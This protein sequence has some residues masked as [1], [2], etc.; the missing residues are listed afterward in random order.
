MEAAADEL[1]AVVRDTAVSWEDYRTV[2]AA[3]GDE[4]PRGLVLHV[5]GRTIEGVRV[6]EVWRSR[7]A[8]EEYVRER[9]GPAE[10]AGLRPLREPTVREVV[11]ERVVVGA[12][13]LTGEGSER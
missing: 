9:L 3:L 11:V 8:L 6:I 4:P 12:T 1:Y 13:V 2:A 5:A 10:T 7:S